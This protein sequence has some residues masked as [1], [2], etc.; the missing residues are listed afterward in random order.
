MNQ[1][2]PLLRCLRWLAILLS[3]VLCSTWL[4]SAHLAHRHFI[5]AWWP[6]LIGS[7]IASVLFVT[8]NLLEGG[9]IGLMVLPTCLLVVGA[10]V[11]FQ[12]YGAADYYY[13]IPA[14]FLTGFVAT[15]GIL[16]PK[17]LS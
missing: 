13:I 2:S 11:K 7:L 6:C 1:V 16:Y 3:M 14:A 17:F 4:I 15:R 12:F 8:L 9:C 10:C 5:S